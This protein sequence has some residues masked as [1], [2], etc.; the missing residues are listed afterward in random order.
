[1]HTATTM[2]AVHLHSGLLAVIIPLA[3]SVNCYFLK[4]FTS[5][6]QIKLNFKGIS[7]TI[8]RHCDKQGQV[9]TSIIGN[10]EVVEEAEV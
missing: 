6:A 2:D 1:M 4:F 5:T 3:P 8:K 7:K 10:S 9:N